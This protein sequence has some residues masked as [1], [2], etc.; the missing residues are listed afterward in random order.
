MTLNTKY[1]VRS[2]NVTNILTQKWFLQRQRTLKIATI[3]SIK[4]NAEGMG[5]MYKGK[6]FEQDFMKSCDEQHFPSVRLYDTT[7]GFAGVKNPCDFI[8]TDTKHMV[9]LELKVVNNSRVFP[10]AN[11]T[12]YQQ[13][14]LYSWDKVLGVHAGLL[15]CFYDDDSLVINTEVYYIPMKKLKKWLSD[16]DRMSIT[17][18]GC[19]DIGIYVPIKI[20]RRRIKLD[21]DTLMH[22]LRGDKLNGEE[23]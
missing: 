4:D 12:E 10:I 2:A 16:H 18:D 11:V 9:M 21:I 20:P 7:N 19:H 22:L 1:W 5:T 8:M 6:E 3:A 23:A 14:Q 17:K 13:E 15:V